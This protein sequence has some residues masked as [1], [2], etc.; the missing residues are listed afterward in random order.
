MYEPEWVEHQVG[1]LRLLRFGIK[2]SRAG[3]DR[4]PIKTAIKKTIGMM[5]TKI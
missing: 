5:S 2:I 3:D 1:Q 4:Q